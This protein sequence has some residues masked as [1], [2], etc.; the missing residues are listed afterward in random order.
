MMPD[1]AARLDAAMALHRAGQLAEAQQAYREILRLQPDH[2]DALNLL[3]VS[4]AQQ[5]E[6]KAALALIDEALRHRRDAMYFVNRARALFELKRFDSSLASCEAALAL[7][8]DSADAHLHRGRALA[9]L[10]RFGDAAASYTRAIE[11]RP[12]DALAWRNR[13]SARQALGDLPGAIADFDRAFGIDRDFHEALLGRSL[14]LLLSGDLRAGWP[15]YETRLGMAG[16][17]YRWHDQPVWDGRAPLQGKTILLH[18]E[19]GIGDTIQFCRYAKPVAQR[20]ARV[21]LEVQPPL[22]PLMA[23]LPGAAAVLARGEPLPPFDLHCPLL[24][25]PGRFETSLDTIPSPGRYLHTPA[26]KVTRWRKALGPRRT[27]RVALVWSGNAQ[28][29]QDARRSIPLAQLLQALPEGLEYVSVQTD[30]RPADAEVLA[31][32]PRIRPI[33][34]ELRDFADT[35][36]LCELCDL[37]VSVDTSV[38]HLAGALLRPAIVMLPFDPDWRWLRDRADSP[39]YPTLRLLRQHQ[40][41]DWSQVLAQLREDLLLRASAR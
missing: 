26:H 38:V 5:S 6:P 34:A 28:H 13:A 4:F 22:L 9:E 36:A 19:Q 12:G 20:G 10:L 32:T 33:G 40:L 30:V 27:P 24:S 1:I 37:L 39:W 14:A 35:A 23:G 8:P 25:L 21:L 17:I 3:G 2:P 11:L 18:A 31:R 16:T 7:K 41:G 29:L 15:G